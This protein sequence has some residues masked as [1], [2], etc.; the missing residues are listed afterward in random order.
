MIDGTFCIIFA[1]PFGI[2]FF[3]MF[4]LAW[5]YAQIFLLRLDDA[6]LNGFWAWIECT[7]NLTWAF[8]FVER[9]NFILHTQTISYKR[10]V[11]HLLFITWIRGNHMTQFGMSGYKLSQFS[12]KKP[13][14]Y[15]IMICFEFSEHK[16]YPLN[17]GTYTAGSGYGYIFRTLNIIRKL[18]TLT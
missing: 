7:W 10:L 14:T 15:T 16:T 17:L 11:Y 8:F 4:L 2:P 12:P 9:P 5:L 6:W 18:V 13:R 3:L 1:A